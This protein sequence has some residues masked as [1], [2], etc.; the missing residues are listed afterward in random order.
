[1][2]RFP[3]GRIFL[4][5]PYELSIQLYDPFFNVRSATDVQ[6]WINL[7]V[8]LLDAEDGVDLGGFARGDAI[9]AAMQQES[10]AGDGDVPGES[11]SSSAAPVR[12][13]TE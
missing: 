13:T 5:A 12:G 11:G 10:F 8:S 6:G 1:M 7:L 3:P 9:L 4:S 2:P